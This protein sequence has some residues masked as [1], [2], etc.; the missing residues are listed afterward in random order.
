MGEWGV[1]GSVQQRQ[2]SHTLRCH[3][4]NIPRYPISPNP[5]WRALGSPS[6]G[7]QQFELQIHANPNGLH[8][9]ALHLAGRAACCGQ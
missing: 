2:V 9:S 1:N 7:G 3:F 8:P 4:P 6:T 5:F